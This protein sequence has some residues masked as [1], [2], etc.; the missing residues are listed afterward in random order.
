MLI[1]PTLKKAATVLLA[2]V[3]AAGMFAGCGSGN[4]GSTA[5]PAASSTAA[6]SAASTASQA[7]AAG[8]E[9]PA[10]E[11]T[12][13]IAW[14]G[15]QL[16]NDTTT[17]M[18]NAYVAENPHIKY[19]AEFTDWSGYWDKLAT[20]AASNNLPDIIQQDYAY[21]AQYHS[22]GQLANLTEQV[23]AGR[24]DISDVS[25]SILSL[26]SFDGQLYAL[27]AGV[28]AVGML[29]N[30]RLAAEAG[31]DV[32]L[33]FTY[34]ELMDMNAKVFAAT[35]VRGETPGGNG[36]I[37]MMSRDVG[38]VFFD[39]ANGKI[40][41]SEATVLR[42]FQQVKSTITSDWSVTVDVMQ[43]SSTAGVENSTLSTVKSWNTFPGG[44]NM[45]AAHQ[46][47]M[48]D[49][50][51]MVMY[52][53]VDDATKESMYLRP[54][55]FFSITESSTNKEAAADILNYYTNSEAAQD[56]LRAERGVPVSSKMADYLSPQLEPVQQKIFAYIAEV[57][58]VAVPFDPPQP[59]GAN[60]V[61]KLLDDLTDLVRYGELSPEDAAARFLPEANDILAKATA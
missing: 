26:G 39:V 38:E 56:L 57:T 3:L 29:Y 43:E 20:Q 8:S 10:G 31:V 12:I 18:L 34:Q 37:T 41:S 15:N 27:C 32:P 13:R 24:L 11:A 1:N 58:E 45:M 36:G 7:P 59:A 2:G 25:E 55:M 50:L 28:N 9:A 53:A 40:G 22:K 17:A 48:D 51:A 30:T 14:W 46:A 52:P 6:S 42:Y 47:P 60:E 44:S 33:R 16:R 61:N 21:I 5:S 19:E 35:G 49:E 4:S 23:D 54:A